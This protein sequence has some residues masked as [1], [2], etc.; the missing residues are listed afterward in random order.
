MEAMIVTRVTVKGVVGWEWSQ[1]KR[2]KGEEIEWKA[3]ELI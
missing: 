2:E 1:G 3:C